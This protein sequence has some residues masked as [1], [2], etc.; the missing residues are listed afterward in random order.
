MLLLWGTYYGMPHGYMLDTWI[1]VS[2]ICDGVLQSMWK[3]SFVGFKACPATFELCFTMCVLEMISEDPIT[4]TAAVL[5]S[6]CQL[7]SMIKF[8]TKLVSTYS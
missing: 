2:N 8:V 7:S 6:D 4:R 3:A 5:T 1:L